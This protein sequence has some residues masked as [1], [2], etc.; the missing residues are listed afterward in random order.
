MYFRRVH[1]DQIDSTN[2]WPKRQMHL[3]SNEQMWLVTALH[4]TAGRGR[5]ERTWMAEAGKNV[6]A[7]FC[8][9]PPV[10]ELRYLHHMAQLGGVVVSQALKKLGFAPKLKWPNDV[11]LDGKKVAGILCETC[12]SGK[13]LMMMMG[14]G[15]N[16]NA[17]L[18]FLKTIGRPA[19]SLF[20]EGE[21]QIDVELVVDLLHEE[22]TTALQQYR[23]KGCSWLLEEYQNHLEHVPGDL[24]RFHH[25]GTV[26]EGTFRGMTVEGTL[27]LQTPAGHLSSF[28]ATELL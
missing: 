10:V 21:K 14:I 15:I 2:N 12:S 20:V 7:T 22:I 28:S 16:V 1:F 6:H 27:L 5:R 4:Q 17:S 24:I 13:D 11:L 18:D 3:W 25:G 23:E 26:I 19:T 8:F 9:H